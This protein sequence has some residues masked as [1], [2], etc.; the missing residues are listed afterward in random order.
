MDLLKRELAIIIIV[1]IARK[2]KVI[3]AYGIP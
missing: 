1:I 2:V 3:L